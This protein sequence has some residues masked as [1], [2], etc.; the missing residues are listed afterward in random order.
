MSRKKVIINILFILLTATGPV[1]AQKHVIQ[2]SSGEKIAK[3]YMQSFYS[4][5]LN[6]IVNLTHPETIETL[7]NNILN[8]LD[9]AQK[10]GTLSEFKSTTGLTQSVETIRV[11]ESSKIYSTVIQTNF[12]R[13]PKQISN[14]LRKSKIKILNSTRIDSSTLHVS[15]GINDTSGQYQKGKLSLKLY[16]GKWKVFAPIA[17]E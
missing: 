13:T 7:A 11:L 10:N 16:K 15:M 12:D 2:D 4:Q 9:N 14:E 3:Q 8:L 17:N 5:D 6:N 1:F